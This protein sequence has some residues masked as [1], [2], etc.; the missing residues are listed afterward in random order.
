MKIL[1][2]V[3]LL[4]LAP[5]LALAGGG[6]NMGGG[7]KGKKTLEQ[8]APS[9]NFLMEKQMAEIAVFSGIEFEKS[10]VSSISSNEKDNVIFEDDVFR[11]L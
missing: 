6:G 7:G 3:T 4:A 10:F 2:M 9:E 11:F 8:V 5:S 1:L